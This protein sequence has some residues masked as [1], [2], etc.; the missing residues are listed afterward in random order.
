M[1]HSADHVS[2]VRFAENPVLPAFRRDLVVVPQ[3]FRER[4]SY[5]VKDPVALKYLRIGAREYAVARLLDGKHT[6]FETLETLR[7]KFPAENISRAEL[8]QILHSF[9]SLSLLELS[10]DVS[11]GLFHTMRERVKKMR[12]QRRALAILGSLVSFK[13]SLFDPDV[14]LLKMNRRLNFLWT[15]QAVSVLALMMSCA[16]WLLLSDWHRL[17]EKTPDFFSFENLA[18]LWV[19]MILVKI[20]HE[21][22]HGLS[23]KHFGGAVHDMGAL[24]IIFTPFLF[25]DATDSWTFPNKWKRIIVNMAGI[26]LELFLASIAAMFWVL[27]EPGVLSALAFNVMLVSS[28]ITVFF[29]INPLMK[30][31][32]Y[33]ALS[34]FLEIPNLKERSEKTLVQRLAAALTGLRVG[35]PDPIIRNVMGLVLL[36]AVL[37]YLWMIGIAY[38]LLSALGHALEPIGLDRAFQAGASVVLIGGVVVPVVKVGGAIRHAL[39]G[40]GGDRTARKRFIGRLCGLSIIIIAILL[41]PAPLNLNTVCLIEGQNRANVVATTAGFLKELHAGYGDVVKKGVLLASLSNPEAELLASRAAARLSIAESLL[42]LSISRD[43]TGTIPKWRSE[44]ND[45]QT[46]LTEAQADLSGLKVFAPI[47]GRIVEGA[48]PVQVGELF[49]EGERLMEIIPAGEIHAV[50]A[51]DQNGVGI[52]ESG[53]KVRFR[54]RSDPSRTFLGEVLKVSFQSSEEL[55]HAAMAV[56]V[57]GT[58]PTRQDPAAK[59][60]VVAAEGMFLAEI[61]IRDPGDSLRPGMTGRAHIFCGH[62]ALGMQF[63]RWFRGHFRKDYGF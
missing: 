50:A 41:V 31:D 20:V 39:Q 12:A 11:L 45:A 58:V 7:L 4:P 40:E 32:G 9:L 59:A 46:A 19:L 37:S 21:F 44:R 56:S 14:L 22:G 18:M 26:Y 10:S 62:Q 34:D 17:S 52:V 28:L 24:F 3:S 42:A 6:L 55:P 23:C 53:Q 35:V 29:N 2:R 15:W 61:A 16:L 5:V 49:Q 57:G 51:L 48:K 36:Y 47:D 8:D 25:C 1:S 27:A 60:G 33:Y 30:F 38:R 43:A 63:W 13:I 54:L